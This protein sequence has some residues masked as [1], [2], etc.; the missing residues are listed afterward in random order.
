MRLIA[1]ATQLFLRALSDL[2]F[3]RRAKALIQEDG[4]AAALPA[5]P[6]PPVR[7]DAL[8]LL[9]SLQREGRLLDFLMEE[10]DA[11]PDD[12]VGA[13]A[14]D[15]HRDCRKVVDRLFAPEPLRSDEEGS[16]VEVPK[17][18]DPAETRLSGS[19]VGEPPFRGTLEHHGW[20]ATRCDLPEWTGREASALVLAPAEV[21]V[22]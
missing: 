1:I 7:S 14:R 17:G 5:A 3:A 20:R 11:Y 21:E 12:H 16:A 13:A 6:P 18:Y 15:V 19:V 4:D 22:G 2:D 8:T 10:L 9:A